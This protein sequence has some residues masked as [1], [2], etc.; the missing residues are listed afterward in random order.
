MVDNIAN[1]QDNV[2][3]TVALTLEQVLN[4]FS[5]EYSGLKFVY[6]EQLSYETAVAKFRA[7]NNMSGSVSLSYPLLAFRRSVLRYVENKAPGRRM[8]GQLIKQR[9][10]MNHT[11]ILRSVHG[12]YDL[13][14]MFI[15][16]NVLVLENFEISYLSEEGISANKSLELTLPEEFGSAKLQYFLEYH[17]LESKEFNDATNFFKI[18]GGSIVVRG[19]YLVFRGESTHIKSINARIRDLMNTGI[20]YGDLQIT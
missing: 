5:Q 2:L 13:E 14:F 17:P 8:S 10:D 15:T 6:D 4:L 12:E 1:S 11:N 7:D 19:F 16:D 18:V 20:V 3:T 9:V